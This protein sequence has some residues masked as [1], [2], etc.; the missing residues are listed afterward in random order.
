MSCISEMRP[1]LTDSNS[2]PCHVQWA[3]QHPVNHVLIQLYCTG[4]DHISEHSDKMIAVVLD[5]HIV[6]FSYGAT[7]CVT[8]VERLLP[9][10]S[11]RLCMQREKLGRAAPSKL[12]TRLDARSPTHL[13]PC[14]DALPP[15]ATRASALWRAVHEGRDAPIHVHTHRVPRHLARVAPCTHTPRPPH[16]RRTAPSH[17]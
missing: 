9:D 17:P 4:T 1:V 13:P 14:A 6:N 8:V 15:G 2:D 11:G 3:L 10:H 7:R 12:H 5:S 16:A